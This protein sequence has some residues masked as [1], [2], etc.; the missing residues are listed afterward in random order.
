MHPGPQSRPQGP[1][2]VAAH[3]DRGGDQDEQ[4]WEL[5]EAVG[6]EREGQADEEVPAG[7][8][9]IGDAPLRQGMPFRSPVGEHAPRSTPGVEDERHNG[10]PIVSS[11]PFIQ[12]VGGRPTRVPARWSMARS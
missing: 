8:D 9:Q 6:H 11:L 2:D 5:D 10:T 1:E 4:A 7:R 3:A 12:W